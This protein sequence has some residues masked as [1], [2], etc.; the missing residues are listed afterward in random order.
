MIHSITTCGQQSLSH[1]RYVFISIYSGAYKGN[2]LDMIVS[3][4]GFLEGYDRDSTSS[5]AGL[6]TTSKHYSSPCN[7]LTTKQGYLHKNISPA[8]VLIPRRSDIMTS[9]TALA[10]QDDTTVTRRLEQSDIFQESGLPVPFFVE[11]NAYKTLCAA[12]S[13]TVLLEV[14]KLLVES[15]VTLPKNVF[16]PFINHLESQDREAAR[17]MYSILKL[18]FGLPTG[19]RNVQPHLS[20]SCCANS[21]SNKSLP[22]MTSIPLARQLPPK[23]DK[24]TTRSSKLQQ[25]RSNK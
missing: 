9:T 16:L 15:G 7:A 19:M 24:K 5:D 17:S 23:R 13:C 2:L 14:V 10:K 3:A 4:V 18:E 8:M 1:F 22:R 6:T 12:D 11:E 21:E 20:Y 25:L